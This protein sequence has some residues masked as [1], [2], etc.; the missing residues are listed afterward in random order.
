MR[1]DAA[2]ALMGLLLVVSLGQAQVAKQVRAAEVQRK[3]DSMRIERY[4]EW[5]AE[6]KYIDANENDDSI[7]AS[8]TLRRDTFE[9]RR[10]L[11]EYFDSTL[12]VEVWDMFEGSDE[13]IAAL[14]AIDLNGDGRRD[15]VYDGPTTGEPSVTQLYINTGNGYERVFIGQEHFTDL[16]FKENRLNEFTLRASGCCAEIWKL[17]HRYKVAYV[18]GRMTFALD[19]TIGSVDET[20]KPEQLVVNG[21]EFSVSSKDAKLSSDCYDLRGIE[22]SDHFQ[23]YGNLI[24]TYK[25][26]ARGRVLGTKKLG[27][28]HWVYVQMTP[29]SKTI[30]SHPVFAAQPTYM[31]GWMRSADTDLK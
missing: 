19:H 10:F 2:S 16:V 5:R 8:R 13:L 29:S 30:M 15:I 25:E 1:A 3:R 11:E 28:V 22:R 27:A 31:R 17:N 21:P 24:A 4:E 26:G 18:S 7:L 20:E 12:K 14:Y 6:I 23:F 9:L